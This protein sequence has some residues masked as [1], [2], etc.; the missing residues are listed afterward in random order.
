MQTNE[1]LASGGCLPHSGYAVI[2]EHPLEE[3]PVC[4]LQNADE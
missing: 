3:D 4:F 2:S 1:K